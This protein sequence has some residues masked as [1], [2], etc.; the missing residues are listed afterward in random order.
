LAPLLVPGIDVDDKTKP[1]RAEC[2]KSF[3]VAERLSLWDIPLLDWLPM[4]AANVVEACHAWSRKRGMPVAL[5]IDEAQG[6]GIWLG[7]ARESAGI[8]LSV[9]LDFFDFRY[10]WAPIRLQ[11]RDELG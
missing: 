5:L 7:N 2:P 9:A 8:P 4:P 11:A 6:P 10:C 1:C 3:L